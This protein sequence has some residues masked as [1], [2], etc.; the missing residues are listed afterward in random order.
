[1]AGEKSLFHID[2]LVI[3]GAP[4][5]IEDST[6]QITGAARSENTVVPSSQGDDYTSR[7][8]VPTTVTFKL[9]FGA[10]ESVEDFS[11]VSDSQVV[12][13]DKV[14]GKRALMPRCSFASLGV[15]GAG[16]VDVTLNVLAPIQWI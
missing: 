7:K 12:C 8:R 9:Q 13:R 4:I 5:A 11:F 3:D 10:N 16:S 15:I 2:E 6:A 14:N 1:M